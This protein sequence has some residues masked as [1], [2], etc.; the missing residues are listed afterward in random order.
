M[1]INLSND[2]Y[3][4]VHNEIDFFNL[5]VIEA[6]DLEKMTESMTAFPSTTQDI[7]NFNSI[8]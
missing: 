7:S 3:V 8:R 2:F 4:N 5:D 6:R 1:D